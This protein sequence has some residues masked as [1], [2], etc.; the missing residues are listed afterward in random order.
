MTLMMARETAKGCPHKWR[1][2][3]PKYSRG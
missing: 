2:G 1:T 3:S